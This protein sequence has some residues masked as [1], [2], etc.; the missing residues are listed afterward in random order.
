MAGD[1]R[2]VRLI[3]ATIVAPLLGGAVS[4]AAFVLI[5]GGVTEISLHLARHGAVFGLVFGVLL[6][7]PAM[8]L[9]GLPLHALFMRRRWRGVWIYGASAAGIGAI[10]SAGYAFFDFGPG[11]TPILRFAVLGAGTGALCGLLF[12]LI[13]RPD[14]EADTAQ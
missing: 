3:A 12:W 14:R 4:G 10:A 13:R 9:G 7:I 8:L 1:A 2:A 11:I 6:G 5:T